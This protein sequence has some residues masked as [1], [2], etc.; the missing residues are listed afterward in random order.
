MTMKTSLPYLLWASMMLCA[1][2][3]N[4]WAQPAALES[5]STLVT[6]DSLITIVAAEGDR[7]FDLAAT[8]QLPLV[9]LLS[10]QDS[11]AAPIAA[12][13]LIT[14]PHREPETVAVTHRVERGQNLYRISIAYGVSV[15]DLR[16]ANGLRNNNIEIGQVLTIPGKSEAVSSAPT[17]PEENHPRG[18]AGVLPQNYQGRIMASGYGYNPSEAILAHPTWPLGTQVLLQATDSGAESV[19]TVLDRGPIDPRLSLEISQSVADDLGWTDDT[20]DV[21]FVRIP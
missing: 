10:L 9:T 11:I 7:W 13:T 6:A 20:G 8:Y 2:H 21:T 18:R 19:G 17:L 1:T 3:S 4:A 15:E 14:V 5:D 12:G 16:T